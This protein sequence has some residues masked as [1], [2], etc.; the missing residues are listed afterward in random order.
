MLI[1]STK[2]ATLFQ[3]CFLLL[4]ALFSLSI[5]FY[6]R[7]INPNFNFLMNK[8]QIFIHNSIYDSFL[9]PYLLPDEK[10]L[11]YKYLDTSHVYF[12]F[13][14]GGFTHQAAKRNLKIYSVE[15]SD[16][17]HYILKKEFENIEKKIANL[18]LKTRESEHLTNF[19]IDITY[20]L[21]ELQSNLKLSDQDRQKFVRIYNHSK[22]H[23]DFIV[24]HS[25]YPFSCVMNLHNE[26]NNNT[27]IF[28]HG[29]EKKQNC[30]L[31]T[32][33]YNII[34]QADRSYILVKKPQEIKLTK[35]VLKKVEHDDFRFKNK[36]IVKVSK[37]MKNFYQIYEKYKYW[38]NSMSIKPKINNVWIFWYQGYN[39]LPKI[40]QMCIQTLVQHLHNGQITYLNKSNYNQYV[41]IPQFVIEKF[42]AKKMTITH[43]SDILRSAILSTH[44]GLWLDATIFVSQD[45]PSYIFDLPYFTIHCKND[46]SSVMG[47]WAGF[48]QNSYKNS[49]VP[50]FCAEVLF[51]YWEKFDYRIDYLQ[52]DYFMHFGFDYIPAFRRIVESVPLSNDV[53]ELINSV[54]SVYSKDK[55]K[56]VMKKSIFF[57]MSW[58]KEFMNEI[59]GKKTIYGYLEDKLLKYI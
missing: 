3:K 38:N 19:H 54:N 57:K 28:L 1:Q 22:Y 43:F 31:I 36:K 47:K 56:S 25:L 27:I 24:I 35:E 52:L 37:L 40:V 21:V 15:I 45:I 44:G 10:R 20:I 42:E 9:E 30:S 39:S 33:Y 5:F 7:N 18:D 17:W 26:I 29:L 58:K 2:C 23:A 6:P 8:N 53:Y 51:A 14:S 49:V 12:E 11:F 13:G 55:L 59:N 50:K 41:N 32:E 34:E 4:F 48:L 16:S 46:F